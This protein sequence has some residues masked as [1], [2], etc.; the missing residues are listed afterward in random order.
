MEK[1]CCN[2][3]SG[4]RKIRVWMSLTLN[5]LLSIS[6]IKFYH[7]FKVDKEWMSWRWFYVL[8]P[9]L[10]YL[11]SLWLELVCKMYLSNNWRPSLPKNSIVLHPR[12]NIGGLNLL[13]GGWVGLGGLGGIWCIRV[14]WSFTFP[15]ILK[16]LKSNKT[17]KH[18]RRSP[19]GHLA[20]N[21]GSVPLPGRE[22]GQR[23]AM[24]TL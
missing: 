11:S 19:R 23:G 16:I 8:N 7:D 6:G 20:L 15:A 12:P 4:E 22:R 21:L 17:R 5:L 1:A 9:T 3:N 13:R 10:W 14:P 24:K 2:T 18:L